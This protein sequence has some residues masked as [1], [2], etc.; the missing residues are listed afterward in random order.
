MPDLPS[1]A[2][3]APRRITITIANST[4]ERLAER[5]LM[6]G[7]SLSNLASFL[8]ESA[9]NGPDPAAVQAVAWAPPGAAAGAPTRWVPVAP[10]PA[11]SLA[12]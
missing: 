2:T 1:Y 6:E 5:S 7:R 9:L 12:R 4:F 3:R 10:Q 11:R 8:L